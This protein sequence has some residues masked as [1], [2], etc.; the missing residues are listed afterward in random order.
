VYLQHDAKDSTL[1]SY[2]EHIIPKLNEHA[3]A[4]S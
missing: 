4:K 3:R 2:G 1:L